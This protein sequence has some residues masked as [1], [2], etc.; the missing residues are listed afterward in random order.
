MWEFVALLVLIFGTT[1][2]LATAWLVGQCVSLR[3]LMMVA[4]ATGSPR[5]CLEYVWFC[6]KR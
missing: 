2:L 5:A 6:T 1:A 3:D 4:R